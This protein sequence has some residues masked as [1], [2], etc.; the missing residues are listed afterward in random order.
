MCGMFATVVAA[1]SVWPVAASSELFSRRGTCM[2]VIRDNRNAT[3][4]TWCKSRQTSL[5]TQTLNFGIS[6]LGHICYYIYYHF[7]FG[8]TTAIFGPESPQCWFEFTPRTQQSSV[9]LL[10]TRDRHDNTNLYERQTSML[11]V[12]FEAAIPAS[13]RPQSWYQQI[14]SNI[15]IF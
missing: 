10:W 7:F 13:E 14:Q 9:G 6:H 3:L 5:P 1:R 11:P 15:K 2:V 4:P 8:G 12:G